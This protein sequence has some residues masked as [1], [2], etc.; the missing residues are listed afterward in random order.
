M[1]K[2]LCRGNIVR[3]EQYGCRAHYTLCPQST[4]WPANEI[5][6][7]VKAT[8]CMLNLQ[9]NGMEATKCGKGCR[10]C[11]HSLGSWEVSCCRKA[12]RRCLPSSGMRWERR[13][14]TRM[15]S[16]T[17]STCCCADPCAC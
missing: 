16:L 17:V 6:V 11:S 13:G 8:Q 5:A 1:L 7:G 9:A 3:Y 14:L 12:L 15:L 10:C 4:Y 2:I